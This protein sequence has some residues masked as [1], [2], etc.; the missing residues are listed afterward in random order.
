MKYLNWI[1]L[2]KTYLVKVDFEDFT[3]QRLIVCKITI[4][5]QEEV[6]KFILNF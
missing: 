2:M 3:L 1:E 4:L 5:F 6:A